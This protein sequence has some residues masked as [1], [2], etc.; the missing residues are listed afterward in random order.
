MLIQGFGKDEYIINV[1]NSMI[2]EWIE[3][4]IHDILEFRGC[5]FETKGHYI[6][7]IMSERC[8]KGRLMP[9]RLSDLYL[10]KPTLHVKLAEDHCFTKPVN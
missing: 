8:G 3:N 2:G 4:L 1:D 5:I 6:P 9:I 7:F 10:P